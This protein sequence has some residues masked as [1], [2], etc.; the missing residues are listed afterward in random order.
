MVAFTV[1]LAL[2]L[3]ACLDFT[4]RYTITDEAL[5]VKSG[6]FS[7]VVPLREINSI[8]PTR[9]PASAP[10]LSV[11]RLLIRYAEDSRLIVS[12]TGNQ[13][14]VAAIKKHMNR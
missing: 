4:A 3:F 13:G 7:W 12:P 14:F 8:E 2:G 11:D 6:P 5:S 9:S 10:A 1:I